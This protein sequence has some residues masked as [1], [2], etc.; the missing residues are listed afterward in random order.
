MKN[1]HRKLALVQP[2]REIIRPIYGVGV[3]FEA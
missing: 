2:E 1:P 3:I